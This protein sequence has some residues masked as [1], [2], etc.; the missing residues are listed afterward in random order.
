[1]G[2]ESL[3]MPRWAMSRRFGVHIHICTIRILQD[4]PEAHIRASFF[5][6]SK[7]NRHIE[8]MHIITAMQTA[9]NPAL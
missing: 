7:S 6:N 8:K 2:K 5:I 3:I 1:M 4:G 9:K